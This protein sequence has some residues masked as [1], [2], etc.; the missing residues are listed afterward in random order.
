MRKAVAFLF[1]LLPRLCLSQ[2]AV[3]W[4]PADFT[5]YAPVAQQ[6]TITPLWSY[7]A[8]GSN[9]V[10]HES[11]S[12]STGTIITSAGKT[13]PGIPGS[14]IVSNVIYGGY[15]V[16]F[17]KFNNPTPVASFTNVFTN[18]TPA[19]VNA[20]DYFGVST[21]STVENQFAYTMAEIDALF[22]GFS[23]GG[24]QPTVTGT[25]GII[26]TTSTRPDGG[27]NFALTVTASGA[28]SF[29]GPGSAVAHNF[30]SF[31]DTTGAAGED[32][33]KSA[34][35]FITPAQQASLSNNIN[36]ANLNLGT[37]PFAVIP[38]PVVTNNMQPVFTNGGWLIT[39]PAGFTFQRADG[40]YLSSNAVTKFWQ[41]VDTNRNFILGSNTIIMSSNNA[42]NGNTFTRFTTTG[43]KAAFDI[44][45]SAT[46]ANPI[47]ALGNWAINGTLDAQ[48]AVTFDSS[49]SLNG[50]TI[51]DWSDLSLD[52]S[53]I[54]TGTF[55]IGRFGLSAPASGHTNI[56]M[57]KSDGS[58]F[59]YDLGT[60]LGLT[61]GA[62]GTVTS[63]GV[64]VPQGM[65]VSGV[66]ITGSGTAAITFNGG[67]LNLAG[68]G[69]TNAAHGSFTNNASNALEVGGTAPANTNV[70]QVDS[71]FGADVFSVNTNG[72]AFFK[73]LFIGGIPVPT[74]NQLIGTTGLHG[75]SWAYLDH[76][77]NLTSTNMFFTTEILSPTSNATNYLLDFQGAD[78]K[79]I[80][81]ANTNANCSFSNIGTN[82]QF[83]LF[84]Y[85][86]TSSVNC[87]ITFPPHVIHNNGWTLTCSNGTMQTFHF[88][89]HTG[90]DPTNVTVTGGDYYHRD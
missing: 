36:A 87:N 47:S 81:S 42:A 44:Y 24:P 72:D 15:E 22:A 55:S 34:A 31:A 2:I 69:V 86:I 48:G 43:N 41:M 19:F 6:I 73:S 76:G 20:K 84:V 5:L 1:L 62:S 66:P 65:S 4:S 32:S 35:S 57:S 90:F 13:L 49:V 39:G 26:V 56:L 45:G 68:G 29:N 89:A 17:F 85:A 33:G 58:Y 7:T 16:Q 54:A 71:I 11:R 64:T 9:V 74:T 77:T 79:V 23:G 50:V 88:E 52:A 8:F 75:D 21:N 28:G 67:N 61:G 18:G 70:F 14:L 80:H 37:I 10:S 30:L 12:F 78:K 27:T 60:L 53:Q 51:N 83:D 25:S 40:F 38:A 3:Q 46:G 63:V 82:R 59:G